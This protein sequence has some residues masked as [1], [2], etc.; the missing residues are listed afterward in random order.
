MTG[1]CADVLSEMPW[2]GGCVAISG[3]GTAVTKFT[4]IFYRD[5]VGV[6]A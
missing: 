5:D 3:A 4:V 1:E 2:S 6:V